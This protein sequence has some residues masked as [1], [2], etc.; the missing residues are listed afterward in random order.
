MRVS[1]LTELKKLTVEGIG[2]LKMFLDS[3]M[4]WLNLMIVLKNIFTKFIPLNWN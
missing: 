2:A 4:T 1:E 3:L